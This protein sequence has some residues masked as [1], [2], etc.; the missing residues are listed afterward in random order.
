LTKARTGGTM[1][2]STIDW[3]GK[4]AS[5]TFFAGCNFRCPYC[6]NASL[7][8]SESGREVDTGDIFRRIERNADMIDAVGFSGGE[9]CLQ[10]EALRD[11]AR[12]ARSIG[13]K[14]FL[15]TNGSVSS[16]V[17]RLL[18]EGLLDY[19]ALDI[20]A[21]LRPESYGE[22]TGITHMTDDVTR[23][24]KAT[25]DECIETKVAF[26]A[27]TTIVP[28]L[29]DQEEQIEELARD[30]AGVQLYVLQQFSPEGN[31]LDQS[32]KNL[33][34]PN[35]EK[36]IRL[37]KAAAQCGVGEV[38]IRTRDRGEEKITP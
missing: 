26:E 9:P 38:R 20:K 27:R 5:M 13:L 34:P 18:G 28:N 16:A 11:L 12:R 10:V 29:I 31:L 23:N 32:F 21:P 35:R 33:A 36:L 30:I 37:A 14:V 7:I 15:N 1:D 4:V 6:Q 17:A 22:V 2:L 24:V 3:H 19:V 25:L 8:P